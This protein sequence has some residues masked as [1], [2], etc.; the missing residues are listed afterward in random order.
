MGN[1][2]SVFFFDFW[3]GADKRRL[4]F[5]EFKTSAGSLSPLTTD[6]AGELD[7]L[8]H[9]SHT[10]GVDGT[11]VG[12][13]EQSDEVGLASLLESHHRCALE[14]E[15]GLEV[16]GDLT[17]QSLEG[18]LPQQELGRFLVSTDF[19]ESYCARPVSVG[20]LHSS[21]GGGALT[22]GLGCQ[23]LS[24]GFSSSGFTGGL[25]GTSHFV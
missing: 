17:D 6:A 9:D 7:V 3:S 23:L 13:L 24:G 16:L 8:G 10:L 18:K 19:S 20:F 25:L 1:N 12:V 22:G 4:A 2:S 11:K 15:V 21:G 14:S 5:A